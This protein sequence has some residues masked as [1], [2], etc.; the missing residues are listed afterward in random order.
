VCRRLTVHLTF[1][2][3]RLG[4]YSAAEMERMQLMPVLHRMHEVLTDVAGFDMFEYGCQGLDVEG[5]IDLVPTTIDPSVRRLRS[6]FGVVSTGGVT[7]LLL[8]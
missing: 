7:P 6:V 5:D 8:A 2:H 4:W 3:R 1:V